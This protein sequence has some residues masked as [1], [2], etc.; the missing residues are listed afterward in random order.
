[1]FYLINRDIIILVLQCTRQ[2]V[3]QG[4][5][6]LV[7][8]VVVQIIV[9]VAHLVRVDHVLDMVKEEDNSITHQKVHLTN[10][11]FYTSSRIILCTTPD[12][13]PLATAPS[14]NYN[15]RSGQAYAGAY[16]GDRNAYEMR[17][18]V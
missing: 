12:Y 2:E 18:K 10:N 5:A 17:Y 11:N 8:E 16:G 13:S 9:L 6:V 3:V 1:M 4:V 14:S 15:N 7:V